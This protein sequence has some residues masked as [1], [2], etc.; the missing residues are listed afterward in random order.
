MADRIVELSDLDPVMRKALAECE[1]TG[2]R[3]LFLRNGR[4]VATVISWDEYLA[5]RE[6]MQ[7][8]PDLE[9]RARLDARDAEVRG[10][11]LFGPEELFVE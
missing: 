11:D 1:L 4:I 10:G 2:Q 6:T 3:S 5:M 8:V 7:L 9:L